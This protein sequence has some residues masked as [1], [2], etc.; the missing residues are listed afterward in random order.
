MKLKIFSSSDIAFFPIQRAGD[1]VER[2]AKEHNEKVL[3]LCFSFFDKVSGG[4]GEVLAA[5]SLVD[6]RLK[7]TMP[8]SFQSFESLSFV[9]LNGKARRLCLFL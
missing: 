2:L 8:D 7:R 4:R 5:M 9:N 6:R 3:F 1:E